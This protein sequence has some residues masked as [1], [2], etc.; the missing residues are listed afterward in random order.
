M[1]LKEKYGVKEDIARDVAKLT[2]GASIKQLLELADLVDNKSVF[3]DWATYWENLTNS[4]EVKEED[5]E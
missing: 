4:N 3:D 1:I 2:D 5:L